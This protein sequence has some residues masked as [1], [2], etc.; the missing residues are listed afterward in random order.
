[1]LR[2]RPYKPSDANLLLDWWKDAS[3]E[4]FVKWSAGNFE[5]PLTMEQLDA[6][7]KKWCE[8]ENGWL[9]TALDESG[10]PVGHFIMRLADYDAGTLRMGF[11][12]V[13]PYIRGKGYG[14]QMVSQALKYAFEILGMKEVS[15]GV[16]ANN[17]KAKECYEKAGFSE[18]EYVPEYLNYKGVTYPAYEMKAVCHE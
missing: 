13:N 3:E 11:I 16:F 10:T 14:G 17:P 5:Y 2:L 8:T 12:V 1:M 18:K 4:D 15:L 9:M 7:Y 6:Y